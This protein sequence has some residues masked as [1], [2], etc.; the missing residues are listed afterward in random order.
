MEYK[1]STITIRVNADLKK[2]L[3][4][5]S[6]QNKIN[7]NTLLNQIISRHVEWC[8][9]AQDLGWITISRRFFLHIINSLGKD[10]LEK[11]GRTIIKEDRQCGVQYLY[12]TIDADSVKKFTSEWNKAANMKCRYF[13]NDDHRCTVQHNMGM[14]FSI[15]YMAALESQFEEV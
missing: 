13:P 7:L 8:E 4:D 2:K 14:N 12:G 5:A 11:L 9:I 15:L 6:E 10:L 3:Q 1:T